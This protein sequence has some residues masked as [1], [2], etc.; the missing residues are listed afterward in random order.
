MS[1]TQA[2]IRPGFVR[3]ALLAGLVVLLAGCLDLSVQ[4][5][6]PVSVTIDPDRTQAAV[7]DSAQFQVNAVGTALVGITV[8]YGDGATDTTYINYP[9]QKAGGKFAH[10]WSDSGDFLV[11]AIAYESTG[12]TDTAS[13]QFSVTAP[14]GA[15]R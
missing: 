15:P 12:Q 6:Q 3:P 13:V 7:G 2:P 1:A 14:A 11:R 8:D 10:A 9:A 4:P 5:G